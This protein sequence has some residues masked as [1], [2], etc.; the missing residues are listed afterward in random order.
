MDKSI[1]VIIFNIGGENAGEVQSLLEGSLPDFIGEVFLAADPE[2]KPLFEGQLPEHVRICREEKDGPYFHGINAAVREAKGEYLYFLAAGDSW[3]PER[4]DSALEFLS[5]APVDIVCFPQGA[6]AL[7][8]KEEKNTNSTGVYDVRLEGQYNVGVFNFLVRKKPGH[9][10]DESLP[11]RC[12]YL[13]YFLGAITP[14]GKFGYLKEGFQV[15]K[16]MRLDRFEIHT[17]EEHVAA[18][19]FLE[20]ILSENA[21]GYA[22]E[23]Q[24]AMA[25]KCLGSLLNEGELLPEQF[26]SQEKSV[27]AGMLASITDRIET[28]NL[29][30]F[31]VFN[32]TCLCYLLSFRKNRITIR[33][34]QRHFG[35]FDGENAI[36]KWQTFGFQIAALKIRG[37]KIVITGILQNPASYLL[38]Y[39]AY[40]LIDGER[41]EIELQPAGRAYNGISP[42]LAKYHRLTL[43]LPRHKKTTARLY[44]ELL[45][46]DYPVKIFLNP[47]IAVCTVRGKKRRLIRGGTKY[48]FA[49]RSLQVQP[50]SIKSRILEQKWDYE[51]FKRQYPQ[52]EKVREQI[53]L[54]KVLHRQRIAL[55]VD[56]LET[57]GFYDHFQRELGKRDGV[58][59]VYCAD[60]VED[61]TDTMVK[62]GGE[63]H[64]LLM[65]RAGEIITTSPKLS[66]YNA[67][68]EDWPYVRDL[69]EYRLYYAHP[70][71]A[72]EAM[73]REFAYG[74]ENLD[75]EVII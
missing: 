35:V 38:E 41:Q 44:V 54:G 63:R 40:L 46:Q 68:Q 23:Y 17:Y 75:G 52:M 19:R 64:R 73:E 71:G 42:S 7:A 20:G 26:G 70:E 74:M 24:Q 22:P 3:E 51:D 66:A 5:Q 59:R 61:E 27:L 34:D 30:K 53:R 9:L 57:P 62:F 60:S 45:G 50:L 14:E 55:Y 49:D 58:F 10:F 56:R 15:H 39:Q 31:K 2:I 29:V 47:Q 32:E 4:L 18:Y 36:F 48:V 65:G 13:S 37:N 8:Y 21:P 11:P 12:A 69:L 72:E 16:K 43:E 6:D 1:S 67:F 33:S 25:A 28:D